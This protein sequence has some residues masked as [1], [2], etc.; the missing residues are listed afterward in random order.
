MPIPQNAVPEVLGLL[1]TLDTLLE[2]GGKLLS[3]AKQEAPE[4]NQKPV[5]DEG[6][7]MDRARAEALRRADALEP[8]DE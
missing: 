7:A 4:L 3:L 2:L 5:D 1:S 8:E 6:D